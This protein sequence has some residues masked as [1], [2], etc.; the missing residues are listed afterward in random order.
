MVSDSAYEGSGQFMLGV[1]T[2]HP[3]M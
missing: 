1:T 3:M 2:A